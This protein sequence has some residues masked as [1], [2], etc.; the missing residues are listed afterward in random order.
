M[1]NEQNG[2]Q[3]WEKM[4]KE[5]FNVT[6]QEKLN[7]VSQ[8]AAIHEIHESQLGINGGQVV[9]NAT[10]YPGVGPIYTTPMNTTGMGNIAA[11]SQL[12]PMSTAP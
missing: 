5:N 2:V 7:W 3:T 1:F 4:L 8:Y 12:D 10:T 6:D 11:P 9:T